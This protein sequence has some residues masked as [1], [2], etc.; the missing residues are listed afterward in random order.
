MV[1]EPATSRVDR[2]ER[3]VPTRTGRRRL[4]G[5]E[6]IARL[7]EEASRLFAEEGWSATTRTL[8]RRLGVTQAL[9]YRYFPS[10][11]SLIEAVLAA[12][13]DGRRG[14][15]RSEL[16]AGGDE[17]LEVCLARFY[18]AYLER[19]D[20]Q[21]LRLFIRGALDGYQVARRYS[22]PLTEKVLT[23]VVSELRAAAGIPDLASRPM[24]RGERELAM[25]LHGSLMFLA[26]RKFV[27][28]MPMPDSFS[29]LIELHVRSFLPG[30]LAEMRRLHKEPG[31]ETLK[32]RQ[33]TPRQRR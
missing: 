29:D 18:E 27:Y 8:A 20:G 3:T 19:L 17:S 15:I 14:A 10:K 25:M 11:Q 33:L 6:R 1:A 24:L 23:P 9:L 2:Q 28:A 21:T 31:H 7:V 22:V 32:V 13:A 5:A 4:R 16:L 12:R 30:A 26:I